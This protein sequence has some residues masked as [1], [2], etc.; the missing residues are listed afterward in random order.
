VIAWIGDYGDSTS[1]TTRTYEVT[2]CRYDAGEYDLP[3][4]ADNPKPP[5][6]PHRRAED[7]YAR[8]LIRRTEKTQGSVA[9]APGPEER[10]P[11]AAQ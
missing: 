4:F 10:G 11:H 9:A 8:K 6:P 7:G 2:Y 1:T 5:D 3:V